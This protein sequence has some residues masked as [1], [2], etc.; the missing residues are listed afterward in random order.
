VRSIYR[1]L[2]IVA[3]LA[4][5]ASVAG[6][7]QA[8]AYTRLQILL[9]GE[10]PSPGG[11]SGKTGVPAQQT[12][13]VPFTVN[14]R[15]C[16]DSWNTVTSITNTVSFTSTNGSA[17]LPGPLGLS[18]GTGTAQVTLNAAGN[19]TVSVD[20]DTD[21]TIPIADSAPVLVL[22]LDG[23]EFSR[24]NQKNQY[25]G[26]PMNMTITAVDPNGDPVTGF[27]GN[28]DL[29][30]I[31]SFGVGRI[32]PS[33]ITMSNGTWSGG[34]TMYRADETSINRGNVNIYA[35]LSSNTAVNGTSDPFTV[36]PGTFSRVQ[37]VVPGEDPWPGSV[38]GVS[39]QPASQ[40][41]GTQF[42]VDVYATDDY[43][44][45]LPSADVVRITSNDSGAS[46]PVSS[47]MSNGWTQLTLSLGTVGA[48]TLTV[49]DQTNGSIQGMTTALIPV[50]SSTADHFEIDPI[51]GPLTA[52]Q[53]VSVTIRAA[54]VGGNTITDYDG[55]ANVAANT[56]PGSITP[57]QITFSNGVWTGP[58]TFRGAGG[59]VRFNVSDFST[60]PHI[61]TSNS[62]QV[63]PGAYVGLQV[64]LP[65]QIPAGGTAAGFI[66]QPDIQA[67]GTPFNVAL[68]AVDAYW[69]R[70]PGVNNL[71][72]L[73]STDQ[74]PNMPVDTTLINGL[75]TFP[76]TLYRAGFQ[77]ITA[78]DLD[79]GGINP[80]TSSQ[81]EV[82]GGTYSRI[83]LIAP[84]EFLA[85]GTAE[86]RAGSPTDQSINF[87]FTV[88]VFATDEWFN[89]IGGPTDVVRITSADPLAQLPADQAM[90]DG[91][92]SMSVRLATGGF[93]QITATNI[94][95]PLM[96]TSTT[97][98]RAISSGFHLEADVAPTAVAAGEAF[99]LTVR[100]T[101]DA[102]AVIQE[103]NSTVTVEV[104][105]ASTQEA[106]RGTLLN[107]Q[108]QLLQGQ[109]AISETYTFAEDIVLV[110]RDD[111]GNTPAVS[112]VIQVSPGAPAA[113]QLSSNPRWVGGNKHATISAAVVDAFDNGV[114]SEVVLFSLV[115]GTG[116]LT[117]IDSLTSAAGVSRADFLS[118]R[119]PDTA[120]IRATS[121]AFWDEL[122]VE[123]ALV[124]PGKPGGYLTNYPNPF[125]PGEQP[126][127]IAY[128]LS[129]NATV[130]MRIYTLTGGLVF[131][132]QFSPGTPGGTVGL[133]EY[134]W[135]GRN[136]DGTVV[137]SGGYIVYIQADGNG[138]TLHQMRRK[139]GVVR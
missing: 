39:G 23:F 129:D 79:D 118:P 24:I 106:G 134:Q 40:S 122:D 15:A 72:G 107:T 108:F 67:A 49:N 60:P 64:L 29:Q 59:A 48:W 90:V 104:Q 77:T 33:L 2:A 96:P 53:S 68:R 30:E 78:T 131:E 135:D 102:G 110:I 47:G 103:I 42:T 65:G 112:E 38:T 113:V 46:T 98:V 50:T 36:H 14:I 26:V 109:R 8:Q 84:G 51:S 11:G 6:E 54:D 111:A 117:Q 137:A 4:A 19:F 95:Q 89:P 37:V 124:D 41:A 52:G 34:L 58:I 127:T 70:V 21:P 86:G 115:S 82:T 22:L 87:A 88:E 32:T 130:K 10:S 28:V 45:P 100:V 105:N 139:L 133:N 62:F 9:P 13:G 35:F 73:S 16:D 57:E 121:G 132:K 1:I 7:V 55:D 97:D 128:K 20:D 99:T 80:H 81:V 69:N 83:V 85:P 92:A 56:G 44:N 31:T 136:G 101:N 5:F 71:I 76:V 123:T 138:E 63:L 43:W 120:R 12:V 93:Q 74:F 119:F 18:N 3:V 17:S 116:S 94:T 25:A 91:Y 75:R 61:G 125:H 126:T 114:P 66:G 27:S